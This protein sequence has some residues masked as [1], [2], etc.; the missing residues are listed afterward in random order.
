MDGYI[1]T[2]PHIYKTYVSPV[3]RI[4]QTFLVRLANC[5]HVTGWQFSSLG[6][7]QTSSVW[8][9]NNI[10][11]ETY[12][13]DDG[14]FWL[15]QC[16]VWS[17]WETLKIIRPEII[18]YFYTAK[19]FPFCISVCRHTAKTIAGQYGFILNSTTQWSHEIFLPV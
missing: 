3:L 18:F 17:Y 15:P 16:E 2:Y 9:R 6:E 1:Y 10:D 5:N 19:I 4:C 13:A 14:W 12:I 11:Q 8:D 7:V